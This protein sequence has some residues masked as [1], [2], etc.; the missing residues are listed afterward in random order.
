MEAL[1]ELAEYCGL[2]YA[3]YTHTVWGY[4]L[5]DYRGARLMVSALGSGS[6]EIGREMQCY[7]GGSPHQ[8]IADFIGRVDVKMGES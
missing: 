2:K 3:V 5:I 6:A 1:V 4:I 8:T 7:E